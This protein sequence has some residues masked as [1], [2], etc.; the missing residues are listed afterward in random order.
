M[1][2]CHLCLCLM[3]DVGMLGFYLHLLVVGLAHFEL[4][5]GGEV[6]LEVSLVNDVYLLL[7]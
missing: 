5:C 3:I 2:G 7:V 6:L 1:L 4:L